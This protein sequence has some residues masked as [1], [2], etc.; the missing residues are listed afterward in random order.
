[1]SPAEARQMRTA[2]RQG[3]ARAQRNTPTAAH[4]RHLNRQ[5]IAL[6]DAYLTSAPPEGN[7]S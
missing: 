5:I 6:A 1:M 4:E 2:A 7:P 3:I